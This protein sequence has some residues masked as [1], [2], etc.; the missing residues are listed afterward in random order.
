MGS[1]CNSFHYRNSLLKSGMKTLMEWSALS[2]KEGNL[3]ACLKKRLVN[4]IVWKLLI[5]NWIRLNHS[6]PCWMQS[7]HFWHESEATRVETSWLSQRVLWFLQSFG[8]AIWWTYR[9]QYLPV[10]V[11]VYIGSGKSTTTG[12]DD[13]S[14]WTSTE[15]SSPEAW[16][17]VDAM[18]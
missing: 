13:S 2:W 5:N 16:P 8:T 1:N 17:K 10:T 9:Q 12:E 7:H 14:G 6:P 11:T 18:D 4:L 3:S 15:L